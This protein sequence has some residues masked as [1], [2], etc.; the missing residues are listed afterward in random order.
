VYFI[1]S[2][3]LL[4]NHESLALPT[5]WTITGAFLAL[6]V[7]VPFRGLS[8]PA[9]SSTWL[10]LFGLAT[11]STVLPVFMLN[12]GIQKLGATRSA[13]MGTLEPVLAALLSMVFL[14][15]RMTALQMVGGAFILASVVVLQLR[16]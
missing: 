6:I 11:I 9:D 1:I 8:L 13:I 4:K 12:K 5:A 15:E 7:T 16:R 2:D 10:N 14:G 3:R